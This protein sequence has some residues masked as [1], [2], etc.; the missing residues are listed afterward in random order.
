MAADDQRYVAL[1]M[2]LQVLTYSENKGDYV[3]ERI[4]RWIEKQLYI[5]ASRLGRRR[6]PEGS[7]GFHSAC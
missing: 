1:S 2:E 6:T 3:N 7:H 5:M 4:F